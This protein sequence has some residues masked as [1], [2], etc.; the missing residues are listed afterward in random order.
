MYGLVQKKYVPI[1]FLRG[2]RGLEFS[3]SS[4]RI[5]LKWTLKK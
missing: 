3:V 5:T 4:L 2:Y 1:M